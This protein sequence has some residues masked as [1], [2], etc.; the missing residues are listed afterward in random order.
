[1]SSLFITRSLSLLRYVTPLKK[2]F[3]LHS[4][5]SCRGFRPDRSR[6]PSVSSKDHR[7]LG[8]SLQSWRV[9][10]Q[11]VRCRRSKIGKKEVYAYFKP[12]RSSLT[13]FRLK[14]SI[15][16]K[17]AM[18]SSFW[19]QYLNVS[20]N[21]RRGK[22]AHCINPLYRTDDQKLY[23]DESVNRLTEAL[24]LFGTICNSR[25]FIRTS[26]VSLDF[27]VF[28]KAIVKVWADRRM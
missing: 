3:Q 7:H 23:E 26:I 28:S 6:Y 13:S 22:L 8:N 18:R 5:N 9:E 20:I 17:A 25:W 16:L 24:S 10:I 12:R 27:E 15:V 21:R 14:G 11:A 2:L 4:Q 1:M 19:W